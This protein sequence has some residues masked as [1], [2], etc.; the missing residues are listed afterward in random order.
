M[1][2]AINSLKPLPSHAFLRFSLFA[3]TRLFCALQHVS[4]GNVPGI[5]AACCSPGSTSALQGDP[6]LVFL[7]SISCISKEKL[8]KKTNQTQVFVIPLSGGS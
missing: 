8:K 1:E 4:V 6:R 7:T 2:K 5:R 3:V